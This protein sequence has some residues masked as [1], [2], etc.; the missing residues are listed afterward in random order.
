M[1]VL[2]FTGWVLSAGDEPG[3]K[4]ADKLGGTGKDTMPKPPTAKVEK[5]TFKIEV[6]AKGF[7]EA[8]EMTEVT[9][10]NLEAWTPMSGGMLMVKRVIEHGTPVRKGDP[11]LWLDTERIDQTIR[12]LESQRKLD[13]L[14]IKQAEEELPLLEKSVPQELAAAERSKKQADEDL[15]NWPKDRAMLISMMDM[16][17]AVE[18]FSLENAREELRQLEKMYRSKDLTEETEEIILKRQRKI[19]ELYTQDLKHTEARRERFLKIELPRRDQDIK[20]RAASAALALEKAKTTLPA[21]LTQKRLALERSKFER[22]KTLTRLEKLKRDRENLTVKAPADGIVYYGKS[23]QGQFSGGMMGMRLQRGQP[24]QGEDTIMTIVQ[25]KVL[26]VRATIEEKDL[27][28]LRPGVKGKITPVSNPDRKLSVTLERLSMVPLPSGNHFDARFTIDTHTAA[29]GLMPG[30]A[31]TIKIVPY[32]K[33]NALTIPPAALFADD[34][35]DERFYVLVLGK[36]GKPEK[37]YVSVGRRTDRKVE[38]LK[39][40]NEGDEV[41]T[42]KPGESKKLDPLL[43]AEA[44]P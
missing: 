24:I 36:D 43:K 8:A 34:A 19:V 42:E 28:H 23:V 25:P 26:T 29:E 22:D 20:D 15:A 2:A 16:M 3:K 14:A 13:D 10:G 18:L 5:G 11:I 9:L 7:F 33:E 32:L 4:P 6:N 41:L 35:D 1:L 38:I 40:V 27:Q 31:G 44:L 17:M 21:L 12:D 30:M 37:R 39:G